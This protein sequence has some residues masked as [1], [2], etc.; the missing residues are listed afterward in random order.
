MVHDEITLTV[1]GGNGGD[2]G[3]SFRREKYVAHGGPD[4]GHGGKGGDVVLTADENLNT[5]YHLRHVGVLAAGNGVRGG[6]KNCTGKNGEDKIV[7]LPVGTLVFDV[8]HSKPLKDLNHH[9][10]KLVI[11][12]GGSGGRGNR[13]FRSS[14]RQAPRTFEK[15]DRGEERRVR[16]ELKMI[17]DV[18]LVGLPNAGKSTLLQAMSAARPKV[19]RYPFTTLRPNLGVVA[20]D[21]YTTFVVADLPGIIEGAHEGVGLGDRFLRHTERTGVVVHLVDVSDEATQPPAEAYRVIRTEMRAYSSALTE[22]PEIVVATKMDLTG[23]R[24]GVEALRKESPTVLPVSA[25]TGRGLD[26]LRRQI[27]QVLGKASS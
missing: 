7:R 27:A 8:R 2:G 19:A 24:N 25:V 20:L 9:K 1:R 16:F 26:D 17:A 4:G 21:E 6:P 12:A 22:K 10:Q 18:G 23:A 11:A 5:L 3:L 13:A 14:T 15:G